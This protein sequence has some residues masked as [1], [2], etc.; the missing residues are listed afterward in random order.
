MILYLSSTE[1][2]NLLDFTGWYDMDSNTP[3]KKMV[4]RFVLKQFI[5][6]D[7]PLYIQERS[8]TDSRSVTLPEDS[9]VRTRH[10]V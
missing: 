3:I 8:L 10:W 6:Y 5:V 1:H 2:T 7:M 4:G 9:K